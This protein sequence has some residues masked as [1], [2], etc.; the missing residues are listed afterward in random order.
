MSGEGK[1]WRP[2]LLSAVWQALTGKTTMTMDVHRAAV[3][4]ECFHKASLIHDDVEDR[5]DTR[6][7]QP[8]I[9]ALYGDAFAI[10]VGDALLGQ[11]YRILA[12]SN[13]AE[14]LRLIADAHV[15]L[16]RGQGE[17]LMWDKTPVTMDF[18]MEIFRNKTVPAF[19][20]SLTLGLSCTGN[21]THLRPILRTYS[22]ALGIA[23]QLKDDLEDFVQDNCPL[24]T[25][26]CQLS[27]VSSQR[28]T[29]VQ[30]LQTEHPA[31]SEEDVKTE[32]QRLTDLYH[33]QAI[34][35][36][37]GLD[38]LELKRLLYQVTEKILG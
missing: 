18:V 9:N 31:W 34:D 19:E 23:Y 26:N 15:K 20:V 6:Y 21:F 24:P 4:V 11:G 16:C 37:N 3:A 12:Q 7:G 38:Q 33:Q 10:N 29:A 17:E 25:A 35:A 1:R 13:N 32:L 2:F 22:E 30:A 27:T 14:L 36:L 5:D 8:T 28:P